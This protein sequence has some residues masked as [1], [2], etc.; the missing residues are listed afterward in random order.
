MENMQHY[1]VNISA[2]NL[3]VICVDE[4]K[5]EERAGRI[6]HCYDNEPQKFSNV[7]E[8]MRMM[9]EL[10]DRISYPQA[11]TVTRYFQETKKNEHSGYCKV[12]PE[13]VAEQREIIEYRGK[14]GTFITYV[15]YR[16]NSDWQGQVSCPEQQ[17]VYQFD[18]T[19]EFLK[20]LS[21]NI[22]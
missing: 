17:R 1:F 15:Q 7:I 20:V 21:G 12:R 8:L 6:Y 10:F 19:L 18:S 5:G 14:E 13:K 4:S 16:Q 2:P 22:R 9:E 3:V 11:S